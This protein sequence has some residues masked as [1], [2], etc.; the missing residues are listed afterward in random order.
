M[1]SPLAYQSKMNNSS[2]FPVAGWTGPSWG[3]RAM[4]QTLHPMKG[5]PQ[6]HTRTYVQ[7]PT[8]KFWNRK[9]VDGAG[10]PAKAIPAR[11]PITI[12]IWGKIIRVTHL[13]IP[14][15]DASLMRAIFSLVF[16]A[17]ACIGETVSFNTTIDNH[18]FQYLPRM[19]TWRRIG[20]Q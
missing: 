15:N 2:S 16:H 1:Q 18:G 6:T 19:S 9:V 8:T 20:Y 11:R 14:E 17:C 4:P 5:W 7:E 12:K 3:D 10:P 13:V